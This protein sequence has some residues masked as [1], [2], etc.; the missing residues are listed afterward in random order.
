MKQKIGALSYIECDISKKYNLDK[1]YNKFD[2]IK[3][4][5]E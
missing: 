1:E 3:H 4:I 2:D 5:R